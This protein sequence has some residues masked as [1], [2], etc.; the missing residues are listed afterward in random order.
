MSAP[1]KNVL[2]LCTG[3]SARSLIAECLINREGRGKFRGFS[4]GSNPTGLPNPHAIALLETLE[5]DT[6]GL[7]SKSWAEFSEAGAPKMDFVFTVCGS[8][9]AETCPIWPGQPISA[10]WGIPDP[11]AVTGTDAE[12]ALAFAE[13]HQLLLDRI[14]TFTNLPIKD[15]DTLSLQTRLD[16]IGKTPDKQ[17]A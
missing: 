7:R 5:Y 14:T 15:L 2:F 1:L 3:N 17:D 13:T 11:A 6:S 16:T 10:H 12:I 9:A 4:A 8:A